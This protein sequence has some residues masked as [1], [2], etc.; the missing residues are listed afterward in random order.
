MGINSAIKAAAVLTIL[1]AG[2]GQLPK[3]VRTVQIAQLKLLKHS[4][5]ASWGKALLLPPSK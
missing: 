5:S 2:T 4:Q 3:L 1:A